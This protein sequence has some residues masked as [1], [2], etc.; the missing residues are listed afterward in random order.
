MVTFKKLEK[1]E[2]CR[3]K[4]KNK[5]I[6]KRKKCRRSMVNRNKSKELCIMYANIQGFRGKKNSLCQVMEELKADVVMLAETMVRDV[7]LDGCVSVTPK[8]STGQNVCVLLSGKCSNC[9]K[10]KIYKPNETINMIGV[11]LEINKY[12][13]IRLYTAHLKQQS[14]N[15]REDIKLQFDEIKNQFRSSNMGREAMLLM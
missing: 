7:K 9:R 10:M 12:C 5:Q 1:P 2:S 11:R 15:N 14:T 13:G 3:P 8:L 6:E 4:N